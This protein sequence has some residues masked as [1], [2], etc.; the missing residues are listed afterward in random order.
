[1]I[2]NGFLLGA[3]TVLVKK[4]WG[5][6]SIFLEQVLR[7]ISSS[8]NLPHLNNSAQALPFGRNILQNI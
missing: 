2:G 1:M 5:W 8:L 6:Q 7:W 3:G 4:I